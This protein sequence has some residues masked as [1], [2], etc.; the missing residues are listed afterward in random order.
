MDTAVVAVVTG[1]DTG[2]DRDRGGRSNVAR[3]RADR[4][5]HDN[6]CFSSFS[7]KKEGI[8]SQE[9]IKRSFTAKIN[10]LKGLTY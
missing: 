1:G 7:I 4:L 9:S 8:C 5:I 2:G 10:C 3:V 6:A